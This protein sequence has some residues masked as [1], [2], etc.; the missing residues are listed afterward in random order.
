MRLG[1]HCGRMWL[2]V[3]SPVIYRYE[4]PFPTFTTKDSSSRSSMVPLSLFRFFDSTMED[5]WLLSRLSEEGVKI[6]VLVDASNSE[7]SA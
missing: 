7:H 3:V 6:R 4:S 2:I 1:K 5:S